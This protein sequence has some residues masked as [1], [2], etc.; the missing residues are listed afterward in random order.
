M[1]EPHKALLSDINPSMCCT[2]G[3]DWILESTTIYWRDTLS[4]RMKMEGDRI[5]RILSMAGAGK[6][7][8]MI[9]LCMSYM[10]VH[11][12]VCV[13][14]WW[15]L[16]PNPFHPFRAN[17]CV[18]PQIKGPSILAR[19][20]LGSPTLLPYI[21]S[22]QYI[23]VLGRIRLWDPLIWLQPFTLTNILIGQNIGRS[24]GQSSII[25]LANTVSFFLF[26]LDLHSCKDC[27]LLRLNYFPTI[28]ITTIFFTHYIAICVS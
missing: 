26:F 8:G 9:F 25:L 10:L 28:L 16:N 14:Q 3:G 18:V 22:Y 23:F 17:K 11:M 19:V 15:D 21:F 12:Y 20:M 13:S 4:D 2:F 6:K 24:V 7:V 5:S 1:E 27:F